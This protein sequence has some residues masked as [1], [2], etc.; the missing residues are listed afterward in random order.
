MLCAF[1]YWRMAQTEK[2]MQTERKEI[3]G[4]LN[5]EQAAAYLN[6][7]PRT[8]SEL[9]RKRM[10]PVIRIATKCVRYSATDLDRAM[11]RLTEKAVS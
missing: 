1:L 6:V 8:I 4:Y 2:A 9:Q 5:R 10:I 7:S 11:S 3:A